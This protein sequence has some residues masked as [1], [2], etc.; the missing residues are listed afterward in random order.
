MR[1]AHAISR[2]LLVALAVAGDAA[3]ASE[4]PLWSVGATTIRGSGASYVLTTAAGER[5]FD[6][7][8]GV[9]VEEIFALRG[10]AFVSARG[11][12]ADRGDLY[13]ALAD[14]LGVHRL[15]APDRSAGR[16]RENAVPLTSP[17]GELAGVAWLEGT[18][19]QSYGIRYAGWDGMRWL[20]PIALAEAA[21]GSQLALAGT[22]LADGSKLLVWS[23]F[24]G[25]DD[26]IV[27]AR[28]DD[29]SWSAARPIAID[30]V[31]PD[32]TPSVVAVPGG[33]LASWS[34]YDGHEYRLVISRF[35]GR[36]WSPPAWAGPAG[37]T[38]PNLSRSSGSSSG[39]LRTW[40]TFA[41][42]HPR[43]WG[44]LELDSSGRVLRQGSVAT[45]LGTRPA[46]AALASG[47]LLLRWASLES[48]V[49]LQ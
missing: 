7:P 30:N 4:A 32:I 44:V 27:A 22:T 28:Y 41:H 1:A 8:S 15:G 35:D 42:V 34:R 36:E 18:N 45:A 5:R 14:E 33:A 39:P 40:L 48:A 13:L 46:L 3:Q 16:T 12:G 29:G 31:V 37:A 11:A 17:D 20:E 26:E 47:E 21:A 25:H 19:R 6:L 24:D 43:G 38:E 23:R 10:T 9:E 49:E 2:L